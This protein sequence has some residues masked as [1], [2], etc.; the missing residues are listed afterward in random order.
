M[1]DALLV[2]L[3]AK[4]TVPLVSIVSLLVWTPDP[5]LCVIWIFGVVPLPV[6]SN[7]NDPDWVYPPLDTTFPVYAVKCPAD[8]V[9]FC[10]II[11]DWV[12]R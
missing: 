2:N 9:L 7:A 11:P 4:I 12:A 1:Y 6:A 5:V 8:D 3:L 10:R